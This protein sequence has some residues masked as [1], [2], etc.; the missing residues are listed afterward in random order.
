VDYTACYLG[1]HAKRE[2]TEAVKVLALKLLDGYDEHVS[3]K[4]LLL[5]G[6]DIQ[7]MLFYCTGLHT[8]GLTGLHCAAYI[9]CVEI[10]KWDVEA[11]GGIGN[12]ALAWAARKGQEEVVRI[13]LKRDEVNPNTPDHYFRTPLSW[14]VR[15]KH[16]RVLG[17]LLEL[18]YVNPNTNDVYGQAPLS[19]AACNGDEG[20]VRM[21]LERN[22]VNTNASGKT[23]KHRSHSRP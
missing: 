17:I 15:N 8:K 6:M 16:E 9:G 22:D 13:L 2:T 14:A 21:L 5:H 11:T 7:D 20:V 19:Q 4:M 3:S 1:A 18:D 23:A 12:T 10:N